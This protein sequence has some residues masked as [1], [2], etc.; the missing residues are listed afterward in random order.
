MS[1]PAGISRETLAQRVREALDSL[2]EEI[3]GT[4]DEFDLRVAEASAE[5]GSSGQDPHRITARML[6]RRVKEARFELKERV[7][8]LESLYDLGLA[9]AGTLDLEVLAD[10]ILLRSISL[11][12]SR[13]G[14]LHL[15]GLGGPAISRSFG[16][17]LL[18][19]GGSGCLEMPS[20][21]MI[22]NDAGTLPTC[23]V[24]LLNCQKC[25]LVP[26]H[27]EG[28][29][30]GVLLVAD[31]ETRDGAVGDFLP[32]DARLLMLFAHQ[33]ATAIETARLHREAIEK[34]R[35]E[36]ELEVAAAIQHEILPRELPRIPRISLA[37]ETRPTRQVG[38]D[39]F[40]FFPMADGRFGFVVAD[41]AGKGV[42]AAL[43]VS[44]LASAFHLQIEDALDPGDLF[45]RV[46]RHLFRF[47]RARK[48]ATA[49]F[50]LLDPESGLLR[51]VSAGHNPA[52]LARATGALEQLPATGRPVGMFHDSK[53]E[54][55]DVHLAREDRLCVYT[56]GITEAQDVSGQEFGLERLA[57]IL[58]ETAG[59]T[60]PETALQTLDTVRFFAGEAPQ[61]DD[62]TLV[63]LSLD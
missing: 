16:G 50:G 23:G 35:L 27:S 60:L 26:I 63:L 34:E 20:E 49:F 14:S 51:Y 58:R 4:P 53:W 5:L 13:S 15:T 62:Q 1:D 47:S 46:N 12:N 38:G 19:P 22:N 21:G 61:Y 56:D 45:R 24:R 33:A 39:Y 55:K 2:G 17:E 32:S 11:T 10:E 37:G 52:F 6:A 18:P 30:L 8:E 3:P 25:L 42:P 7:L 44:T 9:V 40:D 43:L 54:V 28:R 48:Y 57:E 29:R 59:M 41:V 31:K 36:R